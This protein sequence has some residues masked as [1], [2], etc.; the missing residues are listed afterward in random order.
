MDGWMDEHYTSI[1]DI[2]DSKIYEFEDKHNQGNTAI[3]Q[4][5]KMNTGENVNVCG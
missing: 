3:L 4:K 1:L 2:L 5:R